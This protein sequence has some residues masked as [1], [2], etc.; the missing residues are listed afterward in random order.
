MQ[1]LEAGTSQGTWQ[2]AVDGGRHVSPIPL[3]HSGRSGWVSRVEERE[4]DVL[5]AGPVEVDIAQVQLRSTEPDRLCKAA[6]SW[7]PAFWGPSVLGELGRKT[8]QRLKQFT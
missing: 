6:L 7:E 8:S 5:E 4:G 1:T 2:L 3:T